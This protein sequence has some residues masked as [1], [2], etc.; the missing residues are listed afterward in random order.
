MENVSPDAMAYIMAPS[1]GWVNLADCGD[2]PCTGPLN[3]LFSFV[4][5]KYKRSLFN[6]GK[7]FQII[8]NNTGLSP[9]LDSCKPYP[10]MNAYIC[11]SNTLGIMQFESEDADKVDRGMQPIFIGLNGTM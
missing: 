10:A 11:H 4:D 6:H 7:D 1:Q 3:V 5:T 8:S 9:Y 2:F